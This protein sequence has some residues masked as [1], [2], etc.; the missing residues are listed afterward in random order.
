MLPNLDDIAPKLAGMT[1]FLKL[2]GSHGFHQLPL[3]PESSKLTTFIMPFGRYAYQRVPMGTSLGPE[4]FQKKITELLQ[5]LE[6]V[7]AI[8]DDIIVY[9]RD[10]V[11]HDA[12]LTAVLHR[13]NEAGLKLNRDKC[14]FRQAQLEY[15]GHVINSSGIS[16]NPKMVEAIRNLDPP[17]DNTE[18]R[19]VIGMI[20]YLGR[21][22]ENLSTNN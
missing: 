20:N 4:I 10:K 16:P 11:E 5:G 17:K 2:D 12:M 8:M 7:N 9:G 21:Y 15:F 22:V 1:V 13:I 18:L 3:S 19:R 14:L 6:N